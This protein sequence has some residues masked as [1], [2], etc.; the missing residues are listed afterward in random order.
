MA[1]TRA[2]A[3]PVTVRLATAVA[4]IHPWALGAA[5]GIVVAVLVAAIT[6]AHLLILPR[7]APHLELLG[8]Y[9]RGYHVSLAG[10]AI[11]TGWGLLVG[12][13][14]GWVLAF[15]RNLSVRVWLMSVEVKANLGGKDFL[16]GI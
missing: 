10:L 15:V 14:T 5:V 3:D 2:N 7:E 8:Q 6:A 9:L 4:P 11:G 1:L 12:F 13:A 16:D